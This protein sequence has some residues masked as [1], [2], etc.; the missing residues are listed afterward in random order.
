MYLLSDKA[1]V[2]RHSNLKVLQLF[3]FHHDDMAAHQQ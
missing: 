2:Q 3:G 1:V